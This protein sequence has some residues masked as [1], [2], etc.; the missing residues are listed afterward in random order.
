MSKTTFALID[1]NNFYVSCERMF[2][3]DLWQKPVAVL[4]NND[5]CI[6]AR[7]N[8]LKNMGVVM[9]APY[10][11]QK[12]I[13]DKMGCVIFSSNYALY[14]DVSNRVMA[15]IA[16]FFDKIEIYSVD[17][18]FVELPNWSP[19][20]M[21]EICLEL[22]NTVWKWLNIP[23]SIGVGPTKTLA[24][25]ANEKAK[26]DSRK[27]NLYQGYYRVNQGDDL[28]N[29]LSS[30]EIRDVWGIGRK[31]AKK[32]TDNGILTA[33]DFVKAD[34]IWVKTNFSVMGARTQKEL[35]GEQ[36]YGL[37]EK[38]SK[39]G[40]ASTRSFGKPVT[41]LQD[42]ME[43]V[44]SYTTIAADKLRK[45]NLVTNSLSVFLM[46]NRF[47]SSFIHN[48]LDIKLAQ[49]TN[50]TH[51]LVAESLKLVKKL[52]KPGLNYAKA[53]VFLTNLH[54]QE[55]IAFSLFETENRDIEKDK[56]AMTAID[57]INL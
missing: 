34:P 30:V 23:I 52:Y 38:A 39:Q 4:S 45:D 50:S 27:D 43:A 55:K 46:T 49:A 44:S 18:A 25:L 10:F 12:E 2:R 26:K 47:K 24:K 14:N 40:I 19:Q 5:G 57:K 20:E 48:S 11:K 8:E 31:Y 53:G 54:S 13:L 17:E 35:A 51:V 22:K 37:E 9:A 7:S 3:P 42:L 29:V 41:N 1:C 21:Q 28:E 16:A 6:V 36:Y 33:L 32:L 15:V 56:R